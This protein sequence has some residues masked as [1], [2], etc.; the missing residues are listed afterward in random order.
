MVA[1]QHH[2][3]TEAGAEMLAD[4]G[5]AIDAAVAAA[6]ALGVVEPAASGLG[7]QTMMLI[8]TAEPRRTLWPLWWSD[9]AWQ[10]SPPGIQRSMNVPKP[11]NEKKTNFQY[12]LAWL[13]PNFAECGCRIAY[14]GAMG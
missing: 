3:A 5:N 7:G 4:G 14:G 13:A 6:L 8:H 1:T 10:G 9:L 2:L 11:T 12:P